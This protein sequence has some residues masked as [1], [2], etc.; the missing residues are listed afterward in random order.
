[1]FDDFI[2]GNCY[3]IWVYSQIFCYGRWR[4]GFCF[5]FLRGTSYAAT[6]PTVELCVSVHTLSGAA[7]FWTVRTI[8][9]VNLYYLTI[10]QLDKLQIGCTDKFNALFVGLSKTQCQQLCSHT[11]THTHTHARA[12]THARTHTH[13]RGWR[14]YR[15]NL[16]WKTGVESKCRVT[17]DSH[18]SVAED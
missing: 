1:M 18:S 7:V 13:T 14:M 10:R 8:M 6:S 4:F 15:E 17:A 11:H 12:R 9:Q 16:N 3:L 5:N 2:S